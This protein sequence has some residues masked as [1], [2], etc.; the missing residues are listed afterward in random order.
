M[1]SFT[2][3]TSCTLYFCQ[4]N[5]V[6]IVCGEVWWCGVFWFGLV[7]LTE[8]LSVYFL[9]HFFFPKNTLMKAVFCFQKDRN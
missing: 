9:N 1:L 5:P 2:Y 8:I 6:Q 3:L 7:F 4:E